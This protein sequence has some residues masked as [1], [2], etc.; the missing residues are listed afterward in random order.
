MI[1]FVETANKTSMNVMHHTFEKVIYRSDQKMIYAYSDRYDQGN[2][3]LDLG[4]SGK[5]D[6]LYVIG[7]V[8]GGAPHPLHSFP[9][10]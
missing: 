5:N 1:A 8:A 10:R 2:S 3:I 9:A 7:Q 6:P 4:F